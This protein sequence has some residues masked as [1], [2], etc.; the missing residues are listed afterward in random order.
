MRI[1]LL[2]FVA[3]CLAVWAYPVQE[4]P[5]PPV[6][7]TSFFSGTV[8]DLDAEKVTVERAILGK[9]PVK[10]TFAINSD[11]KVEGS[12]R[13]KSRVTVRYAT[14]E[15]GDIALRIVVREKSN[16]KKK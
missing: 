1:L 7:G 13:E 6:D 10:R 9:N 8:T 11:T 12:L 16:A 3:A 15:N 4:P 2:A 14:S 5:A